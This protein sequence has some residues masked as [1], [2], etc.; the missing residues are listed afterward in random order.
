MLWDTWTCCPTN[1]CN[2]IILTFTST[3]SD[4]HISTSG[5]ILSLLD[6]IHYILHPYIS[7]LKNGS[8][9]FSWL[10]LI[11]S[12]SLQQFFLYPPVAATY[13]S[14]QT[15]PSFNNM[16]QTHTRCLALGYMTEIQGQCYIG[17][18]SVLRALI[19]GDTNKNQV[20]ERKKIIT[21]LLDLVR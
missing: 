17:I 8:H 19:Y 15:I 12:S 13:L 7:A 6:N 2:P 4:T 1:S 14:T 11:T 9:S 5:P 3:L 10:E 18:V 16:H 20:E 21:I